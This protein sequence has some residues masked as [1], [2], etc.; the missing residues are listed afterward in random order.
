MKHNQANYISLSAAAKILSVDVATVR[1]LRNTKH[2][3]HARLFNGPA[4][5]LEHQVRALKHHPRI[6]ASAVRAAR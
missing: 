6:V 5:V 4:V 3:K 2:L 1:Q